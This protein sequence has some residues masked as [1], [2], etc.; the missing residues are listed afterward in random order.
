MYKPSKSRWLLVAYVL[1]VNFLLELSI[2]A[3][4]IFVLHRA[5]NLEFFSVRIRI[6]DWIVDLDPTLELYRKQFQKSR[7]H[8]RIKVV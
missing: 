7:F 5:F 3:E 2:I 8:V 6:P 4:V 1:L